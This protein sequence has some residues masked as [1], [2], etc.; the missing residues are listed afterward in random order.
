MK[1]EHKKIAQDAFRFDPRDEVYIVADRGYMDYGIA[2]QAAGS[3]ERV[4]TVRRSEVQEAPKAEKPAKAE[5]ATKAT[6]TAAD[7][8]ETPTPNAE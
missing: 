6:A 8:P 3:K 5:K 2:L 4:T 1:A 7:A